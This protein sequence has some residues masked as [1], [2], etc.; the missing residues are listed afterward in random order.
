[1][2]AAITEAIVASEDRTFWTNEGVDFKGVMRA[3]WNNFTGGETQGASTITQ[4]YARLAFDLKG[5]TYNRKLREAVLAWKMSDELTKEEILES[6]LNSVPFG[7]N[8]Y[9]AEAAARAYF[10]KTINNKAPEAQQITKT[11]AMALV[12]MV[13]QPEARPGRPGRVPGLRPDPQRE[14]EGA[15]ESA[16]GATSATRWSSSSR[17]TRTRA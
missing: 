3:A 8:T 15:G 1:M 7:R 6:Y 13:K 9:G 5:A 12:S 2:N 16:G 11:E 10:G 17:R 14:G 4:Q